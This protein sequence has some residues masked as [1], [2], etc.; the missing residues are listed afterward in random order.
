MTRKFNARISSAQAVALMVIGAVIFLHP[1]FGWATSIITAEGTIENDLFVSAGMS[2]TL[3]DNN[4]VLTLDVENTTNFTNPDDDIFI[5]DIFF[6]MPEDVKIELSSGPSG[7]IMHSSPADTYANGFGEFDISLNL[8]KG[9]SPSAYGIGVGTTQT[10]TFNV[11]GNTTDLE[12]SDFTSILST[13]PPGDDPRI[14]AVK[15]QS[16]PNDESG[17]VGSNGEPPVPTPSPATLPICAIGIVGFF[18]Y[19]GRKRNRR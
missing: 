17:Y 12:E 16:G 11:A 10:F 7:F 8:G 19:Y 15:F 3:S 1:G 4:T 2:F 9:L 14:V 5:T 18:G 6:N 13:I